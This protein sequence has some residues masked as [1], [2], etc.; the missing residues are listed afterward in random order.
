MQD[1]KK[2][3]PNAVINEKT[4]QVTLKGDTVK[5]YEEGTEL[6][7]ELVD[8]KQHNVTIQYDKNFQTGPLS[9]K[10]EN[11]AVSTNPELARFDS[12]K[13]GTDAIVNY[14]PNG[15]E[16]L[17]I[18]SNKQTVNWTREN[19]LGL[20]H[21]LIHSK[22]IISGSSLLYLKNDL[23]GEENLTCSETNV[24]IESMRAHGLTKTVNRPFYK[25]GW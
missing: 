4:G 24:I 19:F 20:A 16:V 8:N 1:I 15:K 17:N 14:N 13:E 5:G 22:H 10:G 2:L 18:G 21:E 7:K 3:A 25:K 6:I 11:G 9:V 23:R 12:K